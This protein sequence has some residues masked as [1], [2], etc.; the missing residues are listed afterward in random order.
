MPNTLWKSPIY[1]LPNEKGEL[2][3]INVTNSVSAGLEAN[4]VIYEVIEF[5]QSHNVNTVLDFGAGALRHC[6]PLLKAG[7]AVCAVEYEEQFQKPKCIEARD[8]AK[9]DANFSQLIFPKD[10]ISDRN[11]FDAVL[12]C[13]VLNVMPL[14]KERIKVVD[15]LY[16]KMNDDSYLLYMAQWGQIKYIDTT[17]KV[18]DGYYKGAKYNY[19][20]FYRE[21]KTPDTHELF[22]GKRLRRIKSYDQGGNVQIFL[23]KKEKKKWV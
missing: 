12:L 20:T 18:S 9:L 22:K 5:F 11:K 7:F 23:Y 16:R 4:S 10:F 2:I 14:P 3:K 1:E 6:F 13:Y 21:T 17:K 19:K 8:L 15:Y